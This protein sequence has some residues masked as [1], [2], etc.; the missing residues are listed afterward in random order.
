MEQMKSD[1]GN[2]KITEF[3]TER[4]RKEKEVLKLGEKNKENVYEK[5]QIS[6]FF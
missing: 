2:I 1:G 6:D 5:E 4:R 3:G